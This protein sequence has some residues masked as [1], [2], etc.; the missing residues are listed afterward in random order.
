[1]AMMVADDGVN[2]VDDDGAMATARRAK[3]F[4]DDDNE[5]DGNG[6]TGDDDGYV[7]YNNIVKLI[8]ISHEEPIAAS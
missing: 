4:N 7:S 8:I 2:N 5:V 6:A 3:G 1:M